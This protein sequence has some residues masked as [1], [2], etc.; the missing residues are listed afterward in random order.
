MSGGG[1]VTVK[2]RWS[3]STCYSEKQTRNSRGPSQSPIIALVQE[4][5]DAEWVL[6]PR[7]PTRGC[8]PSLA[9]EPVLAARGPAT[10]HFSA[11]MQRAITTYID[12]PHLPPA[13]AVAA[14][15]STGS[16]FILPPCRARRCVVSPGVEEL[17]YE[18]LHEGPFV[19]KRGQTWQNRMD[20]QIAPSA[21]RTR[22]RR[23]GC[24]YTAIY[25]PSRLAPHA[26][27]LALVPGSWKWHPSN[28][29]S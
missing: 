12:Q 19:E 22:A 13:V 1:G 26:E 7:W 5:V 27:K 4:I 28:W 8:G 21:V 29:T 2:R 16:P 23:I 10:A 24:C 15:P 14:C 9:P 6:T 3:V 20:S 17:R 25:V 18:P 11:R